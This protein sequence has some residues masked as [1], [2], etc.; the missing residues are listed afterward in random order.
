MKLP[1]PSKLLSMWDIMGD[2]EKNL[3]LTLNSAVFDRE[4]NAT[5]KTVKTENVNNNI[6]Y[7]L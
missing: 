7:S 4:T 1:V 3:V 2:R 6:L 5:I